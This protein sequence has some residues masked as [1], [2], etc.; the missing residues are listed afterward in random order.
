[1]TDIFQEVPADEDLSEHEGGSMKANPQWFLA[2][3]RPKA[4]I[5]EALPKQAQKFVVASTTR[6]AAR[7][8]PINYV[9]HH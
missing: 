1:L 3:P 9:S 6:Q 4:A 5:E 2:Q 8:M 7:K